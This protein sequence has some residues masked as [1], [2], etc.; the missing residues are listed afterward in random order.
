M[1]IKE[2]LKKYKHI[3][4][5]GVGGISMSALAKICI[6]CGI[7]VSGSDII[8]SNITQELERLGAK[9]YYIHNENN[10]VNSD[11]VVYTSAVGENN[12]EVVFARKNN[13]KTLERADFL[14]EICGC[15]KNVIAISGCHGKTTTTAMIGNIFECAGFNPTVHLGGES[16][17]FNSNLKIGGS[18][19]FITEACEYQKHLLK[20]PHTVGVVLNIE[21]DHVECYKNF[22]DLTKTFN[23]FALNSIEKSIVNERYLSFFSNKKNIL[24]FS[25]SHCG[26]FV[27]QNIEIKS[28]R[29]FFDCYKKSKFY[30]K[31]SLNVCG[32]HNV[33]NGLCA[34]AVADYFKV[35]LSDLQKGL[36]T[37]AGIKRRFE[38]MGKINNQIVIHDYAH[39][40]TEIEN[41]MNTA[42]QYFNRKVLVVFQ[43]H[44]YSRT[45]FLFSEFISKL[46]YADKIVI[47]PTY[48]AREKKQDGYD[49]KKLY[50][51]LKKINTETIYFNNY[52]KVKKYL[53]KI[54]NHTILIL[55]AGDIENLAISI[56]KDYLAKK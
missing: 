21:L 30:G 5:V 43:P 13:I 23:N 10:V 3:H 34:I 22:E 20:I 35:K 25:E 52:D 54:E 14:H 31:F 42:R 55:G 9:I 38:Y 50:A 11:L 46:L 24:T 1:E 7:K 32:K 45:K 19:F 26:D 39:H 44:T 40:P 29:L 56:K 6:F 41:A 49:A 36:S 15:Y 16:I 8:K 27:A 17:N 33:Y 28:G 47:F 2:Y 4:L 48:P 51:S 37:F 18:D 53:N 12:V